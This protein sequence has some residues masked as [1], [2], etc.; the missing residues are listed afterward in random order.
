LSLTSVAFGL[1]VFIHG[2]FYWLYTRFWLY[3]D[4]WF[5]EWYATTTNPG[6]AGGS[7]IQQHSQYDHLERLAHDPHLP[8]ALHNLDLGLS[9]LFV[10]FMVGVTLVDWKTRYFKTV[11]KESM[12][13]WQTVRFPADQPPILY[14]GTKW[15]TAVA[16]SIILI[17]VYMQ[18]DKPVIV[19]NYFFSDA[20]EFQKIEWRITKGGFPYLIA[21]FLSSVASIVSVY[22]LAEATKGNRYLMCSSILLLVVIAFGKMASLSKAPIIVYTIQLAVTL[23]L[24]R[25]LKPSIIAVAILVVVGLGGIILMIFVANGDIGRLQ[26][27]FAFLFYRALMIPNE[28][29]VEYF[30]VFPSQIPHTLGFDNK[31]VAFAFGTETIQQSYY[32]VSQSIRGVGGSTTNAM[33]IADSWAQFSWWGLLIFPIVFGALL[34]YLD[35]ALIRNLGKSSIS[36]AG[37]VTGYYGVFIAMSTSL[38]TAFLTGGLLLV[39]SIAWI[40]DKLFDVRSLSKPASYEGK[41]PK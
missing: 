12:T 13:R 38:S 33:F 20:S 4:T 16:V 14:A 25:T 15:L 32:R 8:M 9:L 41:K 18:Y 10:G 40:C 37:L 34:R 5:Y 29:L 2:P 30:L 21:L 27:A 28:S 22:F 24:F 31:F 19:Y 17:V 26:S 7:D 35:V 11:R 3:K 39:L 23:A 36:I 6:G 1:L